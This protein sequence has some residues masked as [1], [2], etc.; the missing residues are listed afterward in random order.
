LHAT[1]ELLRFFRQ[2]DLHGDVSDIDKRLGAES[3]AWPESAAR[4]DEFQAQFF[5][6]LET[7]RGTAENAK[8]AADS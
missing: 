3:F 2:I 5:G 6:D 7:D 1:L 8:E 4:F